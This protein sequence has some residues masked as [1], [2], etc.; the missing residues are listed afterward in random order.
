MD[1]SELRVKLE[2]LSDFED[3]YIEVIFYRSV[4]NKEDEIARLVKRDVGTVRTRFTNI[5]TTLHIE[6]NNKQEQLVKDYG[7]ILLKYMKSEE[8]LKNWGHIRAEMR[9]IA[10]TL[11][12]DTPSITSHGIYPSEPETPITP[13]DS[14]QGESIEPD[15]RSTDGKSQHPR[16]RWP[17][18]VF[19]IPLIILLVVCF[20]AGSFLWN[21]I[22]DIFGAGE[23]AAATEPSVSSL[24]LTEVETGT[25]QLTPAI[26]DTQQPSATQTSIP[27]LVETTVTPP[28]ATADI[29]TETPT[30]EP[31]PTLD[32]STLKLG[33]EFSDNRVAL[34]LTKELKF[35]Q[36]YYGS[37]AVWFYFEFENFSG[38]DIL[39]SYHPA[40]FTLKDNLDR[41]YECWYI[42]RMPYAVKDQQIDRTIKTGSV[43]K[44][45]LG[46]GR[47][48]ELNSQATTLILTAD[49][50]SSLPE[51]VWTIEIPR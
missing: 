51:M 39:L 10:S 45:T 15:T 24:S 9:R 19:A 22:S 26:T 35:N 40:D 46:C 4:G 12:T 7:T 42:L 47:G 14:T 36:E 43:Y 5:F 27:A 16:V 50:F 38:Q 3:I 29:P 6:G 8:D 37:S 21:R 20:I 2:A 48:V 18:L 30:L 17:W 23:I 1:Q 31:S 49:K 32:P 28:T 41:D 13:S 34:K 11:P 25:T 33:D 44:F